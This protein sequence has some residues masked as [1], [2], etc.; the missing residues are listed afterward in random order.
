MGDPHNPNRYGE[1]WSQTKIN[2]Y[3]QELF[4]IAPDVVLSGGWAWHFLSPAGHPEYKHAHDHKDVDVFVNPDKVASV[5]MDLEE[6]GFHKVRTRFDKHQS[7]EEFRRY[8]KV[9]DGDPERFRVTIDFF[10]KE[11]PFR[12]IGEYRVVEP[13]ELLKLYGK[14]HSSENC[15]AV[16]AARKLLAQGIDPQGRAELTQLADDE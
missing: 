5:C 9:I 3:L 4:F 16:T 11:M 10:V 12:Q 13:V 14:I 7:E 6:L 1:V 8:E 15:W 2:A